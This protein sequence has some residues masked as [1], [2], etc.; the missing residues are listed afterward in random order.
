MSAIAVTVITQDDLRAAPA[1]VGDLLRQWAP[2]AEAPVW[3]LNVYTELKDDT[4]AM[5]MDVVT[6]T[7]AVL[8][9]GMHFP[10][11]RHLSKANLAIIARGALLARKGEAVVLSPV[12]VQDWQS[13]VS[14]P[15]TDEIA[16]LLGV[17]PETLDALAKLP[18]DPELLDMVLATIREMNPGIDEVWSAAYSEAL[19]AVTLL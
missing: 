7:G 9:T 15:H 3:D 12:L 10:L 11:W 2:P 16:W 6:P 14:S 17:T 4:I 5:H 18:E 19:T 1:W 8:A 13:F